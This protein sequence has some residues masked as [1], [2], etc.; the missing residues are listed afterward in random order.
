MLQIL[1]QAWREQG[2]LVEAT[3]STA[4]GIRRPLLFVEEGRDAV[5]CEIDAWYDAHGI[6]VE[7][8]VGRGAQ[9]NADYRD[10]VRPL[11]CSTHGSWR[12]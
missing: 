6:A 7:V 9:N 8:E 3:K 4:D 5:S 2:F 1:T 11:F 10:I 12:C